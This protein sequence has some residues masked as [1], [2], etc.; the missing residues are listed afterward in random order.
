[1]IRACHESTAIEPFVWSF[2]R[3]GAGCHP[4]ERIAYG[5]S[6]TSLGSPQGIDE[7]RATMVRGSA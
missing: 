4:L 7:A 3:C 6:D 2:D 1:M 5:I